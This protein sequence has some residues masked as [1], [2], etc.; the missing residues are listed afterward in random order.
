MKVSFELRKEKV[1]SNG[2]IPVQFVLRAEGVRIRRNV[3]VS[4]LEKYWVGSR[5]KPNLKREPNNNYIDINK[6][7]QTVEEKISDIFLFI[8]AN[9]LPFSKELFLSKFDSEA[10]IK[11]VTVEFFECFDVC[12]R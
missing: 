2:L 7:L 1:N 5:V 10:E 6:K 12:V 3:G 9:K 11:A 4:V 8:Q